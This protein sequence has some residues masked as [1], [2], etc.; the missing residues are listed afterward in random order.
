MD[1]QAPLEK[2]PLLMKAS[3]VVSDESK[4]KVIYIYL[5]AVASQQKNGGLCEKT[6]AFPQKKLRKLNQLY[7]RT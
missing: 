1:V 5:S 6:A 3:K 2:E 4:G 7:P